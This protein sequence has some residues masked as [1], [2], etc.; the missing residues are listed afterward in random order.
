MTVTPIPLNKS[1]KILPK[2]SFIY[3]ETRRKVAKEI[4]TAKDIYNSKLQSEIINK[5]NSVHSVVNKLCNLKQKISPVEKIA[6]SENVTVISALNSINEHFAKISNRFEAITNL[7][8]INLNGSNS[9]YVNELA[10][11]KSFENLNIRKSNVPGALPA[12][13]LKFAALHIVPY[14]THVINFSFKEMVV[15]SEWK[16]GFITPVPKEKTNIS[17]ET[18]RP[19]TQTNIYSKIMEGFMFNKIHDQILSKL[20]KNQY[21][22]IRNSSTAYYLVSLFNF[23]L[24]SLDKPNTFVVIVLLDL[25][26]AFDLVDH[27]VLIKCL[28]DIGVCQN[29]IMWIADL[30]RNRKQCTKHHNVLSKLLTIS[31]STP[32]GTKLAVLLF[33]ILINDLLTYFYNKYES[34]NNILNAFVDDMSIAEAV[35]YN[36]PCQINELVNDLNDRMTLNKMSLNAQKS[37]VMVI[38]KSKKKIHSNVNVAINGVQLPRANVGKLL[39]VLINKKAD[40]SDHVDAIYA[41]AFK[42]LYILRKLKCFGFNRIQL[43]NMY[44]LHIRSVLEYC[45]VLWSSALTFNQSKKLVSVEKRALSI[46][47]GVYVSNSN[48]IGICKSLNLVHLTDRW[49][50]LLTSFGISTIKNDKYKHW[51]NAYKIDRK[52]GFTSRNNKNTHNFRAVPARYERYRKSTIPTLIRLLR[53]K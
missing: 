15:P 41:K 26:K 23:V 40:W 4:K 49:S 24:K 8:F 31:N 29:D 52:P 22:A 53:S 20:N 30:L 38:D 33:V 43:A 12:K 37:M 39:G 32:Q 44:V 48:Y 51:L 21:G 19:I 17:I 47:V 3:P 50:K 45:C 28:I 25:S 2:N 7:D 10:V 46:I 6:L 34:P 5:P 35:S 1:F 16:K 36:Q 9:L 13:F 14:Y 11:M 27:N 18:L 42:K